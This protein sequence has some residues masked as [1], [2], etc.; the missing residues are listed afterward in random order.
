MELL[1]RTERGRVRERVALINHRVTKKQEDKARNQIKTE[2]GRM[3]ENTEE[4]EER[5]RSERE[6]RGNK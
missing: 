3:E 6:K 2:I 4:R 5:R 1:H